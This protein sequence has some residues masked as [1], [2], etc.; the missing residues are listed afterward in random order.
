MLLDFCSEF[1][2]FFFEVSGFDVI[3]CVLQG[4]R[5]SPSAFTCNWSGINQECLKNNFFYDRLLK[6]QKTFKKW[7]KMWRTTKTKYRLIIKILLK[8]NILGRIRNTFMIEYILYSNINIYYYIYLSNT[9]TIQNAIN[10]YFLSF[11]NY[12]VTCN[13]KCL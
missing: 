7:E 2:R 3:R 4:F 11:N 8:N 6:K 12:I 9:S 13:C 1:T 10:T 5:C